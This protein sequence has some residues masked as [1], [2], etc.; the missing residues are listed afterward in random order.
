MT[1]GSGKGRQ[2]G[3]GQAVPAI[4][5]KP[6]GARYLLAPR[7]PTQWVRNLRQASEGELRRLATGYPACRVVAQA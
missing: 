5:T 7:G 2:P 3:R 6:P 4:P 1:L